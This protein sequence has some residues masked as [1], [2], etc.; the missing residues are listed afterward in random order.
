MLNHAISNAIAD[1]HRERKRE[2]E[3]ITTEH[4]AQKMRIVFWFNIEFGRF[5]T[6]LHFSFWYTDEY[7]SLIFRATCIH[8]TKLNQHHKKPFFDQSYFNEWKKNIDL[9]KRFAVKKDFFCY[10]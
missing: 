9:K 7:L 10:W 8:I 4:R 5:D 3:K 1:T 6:G 2:K